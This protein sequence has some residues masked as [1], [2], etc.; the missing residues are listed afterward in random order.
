MTRIAS[1]RPIAKRSRVSLLASVQSGPLW[2]NLANEWGVVPALSTSKL[3]VGDAEALGVWVG[4]MTQS[5]L[6]AVAG[7]T[8]SLLLGNSALRRR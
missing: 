5:P 7:D 8:R 3:H 1:E 4:S 2:R 6:M